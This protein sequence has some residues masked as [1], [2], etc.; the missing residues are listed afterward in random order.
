MTSSF[1]FGNINWTKCAIIHR[2]TC[3]D[4]VK[5]EIAKLKYSKMLQKGNLFDVHVKS[6][7]SDDAEA[8]RIS[9]IPCIKSE[10]YNVSYP[11]CT[12]VA[13]WK[14]ECQGYI[15]EKKSQEAL[16]RMCRFFLVART[17]RYGST[18]VLSHFAYVPRGTS[19]CTV[20]NLI[21]YGSEPIV[22]IWDLL[23][24]NNRRSHWKQIL[25]AIKISVSRWSQD[26]VNI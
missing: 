16:G 4:G 25:N 9:K 1:S 11:G 13:Q 5:K 2:A 19:E 24:Q 14:L 23:S 18:G 15:R 12:H 22:Q 6:Q 21:V 26:S 7:E 8:A 20:T 17:A 10:I 3:P